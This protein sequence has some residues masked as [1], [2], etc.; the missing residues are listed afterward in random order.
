M[1]S[2]H[3][4][5]ALLYCA[6]ACCSATDARSGALLGTWICGP[7]D[8]AGNGFNVTL[9][10]TSTYKPDGAYTSTSKS[11]VVTS[12]GR[13]VNIHD[14]SEG[15][16]T[17]KGNII[18]VQTDKVEFLWSD[19]PGYSK[20]GQQISDDQ[21]KAKNWDESLILDLTDKKLVKTPVRSL[22]KGAEVMVSCGRQ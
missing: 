12:D 6:S 5:A 14:Q 19:N 8:M 9:T 13:K 17:L 21:N 11:L 20:I 4:L 16:W 22:Y 3:Y 2:F 15:T 7:M 1:K 10:Y 18:R